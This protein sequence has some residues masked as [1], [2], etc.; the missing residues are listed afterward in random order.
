M[1]PNCTVQITC[2]RMYIVAVH[3]GTHN[4]CTHH[5]VVLAAVRQTWQYLSSH[6]DRRL[7]TS[8]EYWLDWLEVGAPPSVATPTLPL[9]LSGCDGVMDVEPIS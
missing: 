7:L 6:I 2:T 4:Y 5:T 3:G 8:L 9:M 1:L